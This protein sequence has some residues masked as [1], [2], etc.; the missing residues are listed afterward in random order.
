MRRTIRYQGAILR[1]NDILLV[2]HY[3][4][5]GGRSYWLL[6]GGGR[7]EGETEEQCVIREMK[8]ET[9]L[10]V[11]VEQLCMDE[12]SPSDEVYDRHKTYLC[13]ILA[14]EAQAGYEPE[15]EVAG[16]YAIAAV[17]WF[18]LGSEAGWGEK[19][20][21]DRYTYPELKQIQTILGYQPHEAV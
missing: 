10:D 19:V 3:E 7:E 15:P 2:Q 16:H 13:T 1:G 6:P 20:I 8:E 4:I 12:L 5:V 18:D 14:G 11:K 21:S 17:G 9:G